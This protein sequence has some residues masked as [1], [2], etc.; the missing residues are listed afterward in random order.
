[1]IS[2]KEEILINQI[3][4][5]LL[6]VKEGQDWFKSLDS[7]HQQKVLQYLCFVISQ[8]GAT[9][10]DV[11][12]AIKNSGLRS[13]YTP[14]VLLQKGRLREQMGKLCDL[15]C[16]E[17]SKAFSLLLSLFALADKRR[18]TTNCAFGCSHWWHQ[19]LSNKHWGDS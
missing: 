9:E 4:Q 8:A 13:T 10:E 15:P 5:D 11:M 2:M 3:T 12:Q 6:T 18:R 17:Y 7:Q 1:M 16:N 14:C 19:D